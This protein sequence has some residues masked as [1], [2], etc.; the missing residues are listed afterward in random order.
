MLEETE[1]SQPAASERAT[2]P[3]FLCD[4]EELMRP[5]CSGYPLYGKHEGKRYCVFH[6]PGAEKGADFKKAVQR[7]RKA[8]DFNFCGAWF[9][10]EIDFSSTN[11][12]SAVNFSKAN[13][14]KRAHFT[15]STF[16]AL[17]VFTEATF[18]AKADFEKAAFKADAPAYFNDVTFA[19]EADFREAAFNSLADFGRARF[20]LV[21]FDKARFNAQSLF[22]D[23][24]FDEDA[25]FARAVFIGEAEFR[26]AHFGAWANFNHAAFSAEAGFSYTTFIAEA[27][28]SS[29][30]FV[31]NAFFSKVTFGNKADFSY[32][33]FGD[34]V[35]FKGDE[36]KQAFDSKSSLDLQHARIDKPDHVSFHTLTLLPHW[37]VNVDA[38]KVDF[39]NVR[40]DSTISQEIKKLK[41]KEGV[42]SSKEI[43]KLKEKGGVPSSHLLLAVACR[44]L[45]INAEDSH[46]Y[47]EAS[48]FRYWAMELQRK[49][50]WRS[51]EFW[52]NWRQRLEKRFQRF[53]RHPL[54]DPFKRDWL[55]WLYW[56]ASGYG[57]RVFR[58]F[59]FLMAICLFFA[60]SYTKVGFMGPESTPAQEASSATM[61][62]YEGYDLSS[63]RHALIYSLGVMSL[64]RPEPRP[65]TI[66]AHSLVTLEMIFGPVQAALLVLAIRRKFMR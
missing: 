61:R 24:A 51:F 12:N 15:Q 55:S 8:R 22:S 20:N 14:S 37:F 5:A 23:A 45:A 53:S 54:A 3:N 52:D 17:A 30:D 66:A 62:Q 39:T 18:H 59:M 44:Q 21:R 42:R 29:A 2:G 26:R 56:A 43:E 64:Q 48:K 27:I 65:R 36:E 60:W 9:P 28:F 63:F 46:R 11:F 31:K 58:A 38:R 6:Y 35:M 33:S 49:G 32:A 25:Y 50:R 41:E 34:S 10:D 4:C 40:W 47:E 7:K 1:S 19:D 16:N 57:E 13:F